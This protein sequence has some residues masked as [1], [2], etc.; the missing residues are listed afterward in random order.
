[1]VYIQVILRT[2]DH[3]CDLELGGTRTRG[4][5]VLD[6]NPNSEK[7]KNVKVIMQID[8]S[9]YESMLVWAAGG[10]RP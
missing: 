1:M 10:P 8:K 9:L 2:E 3:R 4:M 5:M 7:P 6:R